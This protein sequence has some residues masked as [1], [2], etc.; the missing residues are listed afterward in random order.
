MAA[1]AGRAEWREDALVARFVDEVLPQ[2][3][4]RGL[5]LDGWLDARGEHHVPSRLASLLDAP[6]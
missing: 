2:L 6:R 3:D 5:A 4:A 1:L